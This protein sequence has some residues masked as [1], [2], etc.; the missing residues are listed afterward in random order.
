MAE[1]IVEKELE[2]EAPARD[3]WEAMMDVSAWPEW[4]PFI[5]KASI[6]SGYG[7]L[8][9]GAR[10]RMSVM[11]GGPASVPLSARVTEFDKPSRLA[12]EGGVKGLFHAMHS[13][14]FEDRGAKTRVVSKE[15]FSGLLL[16]VV[17]LM[18]TEGDLEK[19]HE[20][21]LEAI[22]DRMEK[23]EEAATEPD[24]HGH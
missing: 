12:W 3:I 5:T 24:A 18:V 21:W 1:L 15:I 11:V 10:I 8:T 20:R 22:K 17:K 4:K 9:S 16:P 23:K 19:L 13:F 2:V 7:S 14:D 6:G